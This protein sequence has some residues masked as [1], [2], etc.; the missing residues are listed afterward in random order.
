[1]RLSTLARAS[2]AGVDIIHRIANCFRDLMPFRRRDQKLLSHFCE[3]CTA[4]FAVEE[5]E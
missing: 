1:M 4:V 5:V 2:R 3:A